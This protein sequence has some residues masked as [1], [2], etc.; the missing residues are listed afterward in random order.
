SERFSSFIRR[1]TLHLLTRRLAYSCHRFLR[2]SQRDIPVDASD[3]N[4]RAAR[5]D[6][7]AVTAVAFLVFALLEVR[8]IGFDSAVVAARFDVRVDIAN[9]AQ[10]G[11]AVDVVYVNPASGRELGDGSVNLAVHVSE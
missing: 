5:P 10:S 2:L 9:E 1:R 3:R 4:V 7:G 11:V 6:A 8:Q